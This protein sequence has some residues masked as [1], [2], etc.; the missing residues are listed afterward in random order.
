MNRTPF[1]EPDA[2]P[3][4]VLAHDAMEALRARLPPEHGAAAFA[5]DE[6]SPT[7]FFAACG[8]PEPLFAVLLSAMETVSSPERVSL[9]L[10][11]VGLHAAATREGTPKAPCLVSLADLWEHA[12]AT[13]DAS[14]PPREL[15]RRA[16][17]RG[18]AILLSYTSNITAMGT[19]M[20]S[21]DH[22]RA[23]GVLWA[24]EMCDVEGVP[25]R[26][27]AS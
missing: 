6:K 11:L 8:E 3:L 27:G 19:T 7:G 13:L 4:F 22:A 18:A 5:W 26:A 2:D 14:L 9:A 15:A 17:Y 21:L 12:H 20:P 23:Q 10:R 16:F 24:S 1:P 25:P